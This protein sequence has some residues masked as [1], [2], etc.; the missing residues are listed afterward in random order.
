MCLF[1]LTDLLNFLFTL[2]QWGKNFLVE[3]DS[4]YGFVG[5]AFIDNN[6]IVS[7]DKR[8]ESHL[9]KLNTKYRVIL[10]DENARELE[11]NI[12]KEQSLYAHSEEVKSGNKKFSFLFVFDVTLIQALYHELSAVNEDR[13]T[14]REVYHGSLDGMFFTDDSGITL[15]VNSAF[16]KFTGISAS[17]IIGKRFADEIKKVIK[18]NKFF[19]N[20]KKSEFA[21]TT[22]LVMRDNRKYMVTTHPVFGKNKEIKMYVGTMHDVAGLS[23]LFRK[24]EDSGSVTHK[25]SL[26]NLSGVESS[27]RG[28][29]ETVLNPAMMKIYQDIKEF[30]NVDS[31]ILLTG[32]TGVGKDYI[33]TYIHQVSAFNKGDL[34]KV[35]CG[36][37]PEQLLESELF[38]YEEGAF[39]GAKKGGKKGLFEY[40]NN[41]T[42]FLDEIGEMPYLL[43]VKLL[44]ALNDKCFY[45]VGSIVPVQFTARVIAA[46]NANLQELIKEKKFRADLYYRINIIS[47]EIP[48]LRDRPEE[49]LPIAK[50]LLKEY[51]SRYNKFCTFT[52]GVLE[53]FLQYDWPGNIRE[54]K[55]TIERMVL[56]CKTDSIDVDLLPEEMMGAYKKE[57]QHMQAVA[58]PMQDMPL[59]KYIEHYEA[60][61]IGSVLQ[62]S[63][64]LKEAAAKLE[65]SL[66]TLVRK[67]Q[68]YSL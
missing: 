21:V 68:K 29:R 25:D 9:T 49:I 41:G 20:A 51:Y 34:V 63:R 31:T 18:P 58:A 36:A 32:E 37:I 10:G 28:V 5:T 45:R 33:A 55:N 7:I 22:P 26:K 23:G 48:A 46:T 47:F 11:E 2:K 8:L 59:E 4:R 42:L 12:E 61:V 60:Q 62:N 13:S 1:E 64:S 30:A 16:T 43:Q 27:F 54:M 15:F 50:K 39:T 65:I 44:S 66:S 67:K 38:G 19:D 53:A 56:L 57:A 3:N 14:W 24:V 40:A 52:P 17:D 35:N 6:K